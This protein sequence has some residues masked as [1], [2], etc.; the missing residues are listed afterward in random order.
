MHRHLR[1][2]WIFSLGAIVAA[3][4]VVPAQLPTLEPVRTIGCELCDDARQLTNVFDV[5]IT[6]AGEVLASDRS[7]PMIRRFA[8]DGRPLTTF[9]RRGEGPGEFL[10]PVR[11][12]PL[13]SG[14]LHVAD[15]RVRRITRLDAAGAE[16]HTSPLRQGVGDLAL[17]PD[18]EL[19]VLI[20][21]FRGPFELARWRPGT[22]EPLR[23]ATV[24]RSPRPVGEPWSAPSMAVAPSGEIAIAPHG[25]EYRIRRF[26]ADGAPLPDIIRTAKRRERSHD[27][28]PRVLGNSGTT[29][30]SRP[31]APTRAMHYPH[32]A[33]KALHYDAAGR[34]WVLTNR[35]TDGVAIFDVF[36]PGGAFLGEL[37]LDVSVSAYSLGGDYL[38]TASETADGVPVI[39]VWRVRS[40]R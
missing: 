38:A 31:S 30:S 10:W 8:A 6:P 13:A 15:L 12:A 35:G 11:I 17:R 2:P 28:Q 5:V 7:D 36:A 34:L 18:G 27:E 9:G 1:H 26:S 22:P 4:G 20:D 32:F 14:E 25:F 37:R 29:G 3:A 33:E 24:Q 19:L 21:D 23:L 40:R 39:R 16:R